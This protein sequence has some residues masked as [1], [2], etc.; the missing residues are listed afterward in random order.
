MS[1]FFEVLSAWIGLDK[2]A[3]AQV[4]VSLLG[5]FV[6]ILATVAAWLAA[7]SAKLSAFEAREARLEQARP[8]LDFSQN[9]ARVTVRFSYASGITTYSGQSVLDAS[10]RRR[11]GFCAKNFGKGPATNFSYELSHFHDRDRLIFEENRL[12]KI[13]DLGGCKIIRHSDEFYLQTE[14]AAYGFYYQPTNAVSSYN[15]RSIGPKE[16]LNIDL[17]SDLSIAIRNFALTCLLMDE[18]SDRQMYSKDM[19]LKIRYDSVHG[20]NKINTFRITLRGGLIKAY[21]NN[22]PSQWQ[23]NVPES[24]WSILDVS[25]IC[26]IQPLSK[27]KGWWIF[28]E[29]PLRVYF[30]IYKEIF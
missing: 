25:M 17:A 6:A 8:Y 3:T 23:N 24:D 11:F 21:H 16:S 15:M 4:V 22:G 27:I 1:S 18:L 28:R 2:E 20:E 29:R 5:S 12:E 14:Y 9:S 13:F 19:L 30:G 10:S 7:K 26:S